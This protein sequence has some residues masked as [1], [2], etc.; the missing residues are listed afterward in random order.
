VRSTATAFIPSDY[1]SVAITLPCEH[2]QPY[3]YAVDLCGEEP[4][5]RCVSLQDDGRRLIA[6]FGSAVVKLPEWMVQK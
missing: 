5:G 6:L 2:D 4:A 1:R 3:R